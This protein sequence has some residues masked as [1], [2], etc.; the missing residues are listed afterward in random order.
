MF[1]RSAGALVN[2]NGAVPTE[3]LGAYTNGRDA[4]EPARKEAAA[5]ALTSSGIALRHQTRDSVLC[6]EAIV[7][8]AI[9]K[10]FSTAAS[11][12]VHRDRSIICRIRA[13]CRIVARVRQTLININVAVHALGSRLRALKHAALC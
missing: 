3:R 12:R 10:T 7:T 11:V 5:Q 6:N 4:V 13:R 1:A 2:V 9:G 8:E